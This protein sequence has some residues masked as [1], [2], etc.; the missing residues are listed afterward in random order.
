MKSYL[1]KLNKKLQFQVLN[2]VCNSDGSRNYIWVDS[3]L[4]WGNIE[5]IKANCS[6]IFGKMNIVA[7]HLIVVRYN[8]NILPSQ[9][10]IFNN[11]HFYISY[12]LNPNEENKYLEIYCEERK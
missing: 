7:T 11:R 4:L 10:I 6:E 12:I 5:P 3:E 1:N 2:E 9:R 8:S